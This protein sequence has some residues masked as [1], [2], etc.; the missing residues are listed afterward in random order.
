MNRAAPFAVFRRA[1]DFVRFHAIQRA[2]ARETVPREMTSPFYS[3]PYSTM[4]NQNKNCTLCAGAG[5]H[6]LIETTSTLL[7]RVC[8]CV[9]GT[10]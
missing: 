8:V 3:Y 2:R 1:D 7:R 9:G 6:N 5:M 10:K 4:G